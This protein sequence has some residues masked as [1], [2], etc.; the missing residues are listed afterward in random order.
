MNNKERILKMIEEGKLTAAEGL[1]LIEA[2]GETQE[3]KSS[4]RHKQ[5]ETADTSVRKSGFTKLKIRVV[6]EKEEIN[7]NVNIPLSLVKM[8]SSVAGDFDKLIPQ[9]AK[10]TM[11]NNGIDL[12]GL[13]FAKIIE[14]I[15]KGIL[16]NPDIVNIDIQDQEVGL[17]Q[18]RIYVD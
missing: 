3:K 14:S 18:I 5:E 1:D 6:V 17:V 13:D 15:E 10:D 4:Y 12:N 8:L 16:E 9:E 11:K 2:L 7:I